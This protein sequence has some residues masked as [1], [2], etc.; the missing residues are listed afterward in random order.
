MRGLAWLPRPLKGRGAGAP[1]DPFPVSCDCLGCLLLLVWLP[2]TRLFSITMKSK[3]G[4]V[5][6]LGVNGMIS[7]D[8]AHPTSDLAC[9]I[10]SLGTGGG[11]SKLQPALSIYLLYL[12]LSMR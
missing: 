12:S 7:Q 10:L 9:N 6:E 11:A 2:C 1:L 3:T 4:A 8:Q 5:Y